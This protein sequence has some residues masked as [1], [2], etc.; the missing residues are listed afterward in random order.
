MNS[1][2]YFVSETVNVKARH[3]AVHSAALTSSEMDKQF[4]VIIIVCTLLACSSAHA[5]QQNWQILKVPPSI[6]VKLDINAVPEGWEPDM[7]VAKHVLTSITVFDGRPE[8]K[9]ALVYSNL[10]EK[11]SQH[12]LILSW[13]LAPSTKDGIWLQCEYDLTNITLSAPVPAHA[14][15]LKV[16]YSTDIKIS[17]HSEIIQIEYR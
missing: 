7:K 16:T 4:I 3:K 1:L 9:A 13:R 10:T 6:A 8:G 17:G 14:A 15:E 2:A 5:Q 11:K 12:R